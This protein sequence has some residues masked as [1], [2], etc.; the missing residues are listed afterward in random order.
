MRIL[1]TG[2]T[3]CLGRAVR[4]QAGDEHE[5]VA[6]DL[7][8]GDDGEV[9]QGSYADLGLMR[10]LMAGCDAVI[11]TAALHGGYSDTHSPRQFTEMNVLGLQGLLELAVELHVRRFVFSSTMEIV[12]GRNWDSSG[13]AVVDEDTPPNPDWIYPLNKLQCEVLGQHYQ[14]CHGVAFTALRYMAFGD[15][16]APTPRLLARYVMVDDVARANLLAAETNEADFHVLHIGPHTP[17]T[18]ADI[19]RAATAPLAVVDQYWPRGG[20]CLTEAGV[21]LDLSHF[22]PV[23]RIDRARL[24]LGWQPRVGFADYLRTLGWQGK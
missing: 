19:V 12:I 2:G 7:D 23:T 15:D 17:L 9:R 10:E 16:E 20:Q 13:M 4:R 21:N 8:P 3:G 11:H 24:A 14:R 1:L 22:W 6:V 5:I 18:Q